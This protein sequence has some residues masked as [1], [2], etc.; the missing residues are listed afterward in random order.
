MRHHI[1]YYFFGLS[2]FLSIFG[3]LFLSTL[4]SVSSLNLFGNT[5]YYLIRHLVRIAIGL[6]LCFIFLKLPLYFLKKIA[7]VALIA[8]L[9]ILI[10]VFF[11][12][13]NFGGAFRW[14]SIG[15]IT[16]QPAEFLK[17]TSILYLSALLSNKLKETGRRG[18]SFSIK[19]S[20]Y[21]FVHVFLPF[22][23][24]LAAISVILI[25]QPDISTLGI[26][27]ITLLAVYFAAG[28]PLWH[29]IATVLAGIGGAALLVYFKQ[30]RFRN[31][32]R[33]QFPDPFIPCSQHG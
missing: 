22:L 26:I 20:Y 8:N 6:V 30:Y 29:T 19:K 14:I 15:D 23:A 17:I 4:S 12:G 28:T 31:R 21:N 3:L 16:F 33:R 7:L 5:N 9:V 27:T 24:L 10:A 32:E 18:W 13:E 11:V 25:L 1:N 2:I